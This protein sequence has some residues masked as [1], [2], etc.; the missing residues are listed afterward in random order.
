[1]EIETD[2]LDDGIWIGIIISCLPRILQNKARWIS[3]TPYKVT[4]YGN[5]FWSLTILIFSRR[6]SVGDSVEPRGSSVNVITFLRK[7]ESGQLLFMV[8]ITVHH[9]DRRPAVNITTWQ[10]EV[11]DGNCTNVHVAVSWNFVVLIGVY[12]TCIHGL[13]D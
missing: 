12:N 13:L 4:P 1:M 5:D 9:V 8:P 7:L 10:K 6:W 2:T 11:S 3:R